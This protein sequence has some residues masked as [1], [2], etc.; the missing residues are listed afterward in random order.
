MGRCIICGKAVDGRVCDTHEEDVAFEFRGDEP[1]QLVPGR[2]YEGTV[3]GYADFGVFVDV[4]DHITG[5]LHQSELDRRLD[6]LDW[7]PGDAVYAQV[8]RVRDNGNVDL[9]W[10]IRQSERDFRGKLIQDPD[11][12]RD[13]LPEESESEPPDRTGTTGD[14]PAAD[15][16]PATAE[17]E[18]TGGDRSSDGGEAE[19]AATGEG[20]DA[21]T[22]KRE[23]AETGDGDPGGHGTRDADIAAAPTKT[24]EPT[25]E[26][27]RMDV[28]DLG[29]A[30]GTR[31]AV[32]GEVVGIRQTGGPTVFEL[33]DETGTVDVAAFA[34]AGERAHPAIEV[35]DV[36][37][38]VGEV[39]LRRD[40]IQVEREEL[41][42]LEGEAA[43]EVRD[44]MDEALDD[45][46]APEEAALLA[47]HEAVAAVADDLD[48]AAEAIRRA[49][50]DSRPVVLRHTATAD[51]YV[52]G[53]A[54]ER[55]VL[56]L[57][58]EEHTRSDAEYHF[59]DRKPL[60]DPVY[61]MDDAT[62]DVSNMLEAN[63]RH[64]EPLPLVVL[65]DAGSTAESLDALELLSVYGVDAVVVDADD[66]DDAI[67]D[68]AAAV[69]NPALSDTDDR[70]T[71]TAVAANLAARVNADVRSDL[72]HLPAVSYW[73]DA[74]DAYRELADAAGYDGTATRELRE[75]L[76]LAAFYQTYEDKRQLV[77]DLLFGGA[78]TDGDARGLAAHVSTQFRERV[79]GAVE[80]AR[81]NAE[82]REAGDIRF[83][84]L[85]AEAFTDQY[86]FPPTELLVDVLHRREHRDD[87]KQVTVA[88]TD[89][90]LHLRSDGPL[91]VRTVADRVA[92]E[93]PDAGVRAVGGHD[94]RIEFVAGERE[95]VL[96]AGVQSVAELL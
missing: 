23:P 45:R 21:D 47:D 25:T 90:Q 74:P 49:I 40:E 20:S 39:E 8:L 69:V 96:K 7:E 16:E 27:E 32:A 22:G 66:A 85:D 33:R 88:I 95:D 4:G 57:V 2:Y 91:D 42:R 89:D 93:F 92:G 13:M 62:S 31:V 43:A 17:P 41:T 38:V 48:D 6:S 44:R 10:S 58:R 68:A 15:S 1:H 28:T 70:V 29:D 18:P 3:D 54:I 87:R 59:F 60:A 67:A 55:A 37:R 80:T 75:A 64:G 71:T 19:A 61:G 82:V 36:V 46:A 94:G 73:V 24:E 83:T 84:V 30:V 14:E 77:T 9:G 11:A 34:G 53:A 5:L 50:F 12:D 65:V 56:P 76:A 81:A 86:E 35:D 52:A 51:G 26:P 79:D 72:R 63:E 78:P